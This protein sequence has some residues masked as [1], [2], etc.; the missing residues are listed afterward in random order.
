MTPDWNEECLRFWG[1]VLIGEKK[2][3]CAD[4]D[5]LPIDETTT[6]EFACCTC[7]SDEVVS[8]KP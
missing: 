4:W 8:G 1:R 6:D 5:F 2:H 3:W 7:Y